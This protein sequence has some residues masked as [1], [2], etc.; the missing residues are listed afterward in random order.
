M[1]DPFE[2]FDP[3]EPFEPPAAEDAEERPIAPGRRW[4]TPPRAAAV[5]D[6]P[7]RPARKEPSAAPRP[8]GSPAVAPAEV[9]AVVLHELEAVALPELRAAGHRLS[10][11]GHDAEVRTE[12]HEE[13]TRLLF[14][15]GP[16]K[17]PLAVS[18]PGRREYALLE[19]RAG[20][21]RTDAGGQVVASYTA[22]APGAEPVVLGR[23][24][25]RSLTREWVAHRI[26]EFVARTLEQG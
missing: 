9:S 2:T 12:S 11:R 18:V 24:S 23:T 19:F 21:A 26:I 17:G 6:R 1:S 15:F 20:V 7:A 3:F 5:P 22:G 16:D 10:S 4:A 25:V 13:E 14:R 8:G